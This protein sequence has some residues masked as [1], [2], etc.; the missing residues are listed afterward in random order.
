MHIHDA[1]TTYVIDTASFL[2]VVGTILDIIP[3]FTAVLSL[4]WI[5]LRIYESVT[6]KAF[7]AQRRAEVKRRESCR[8]GDRG[9]G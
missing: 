7:L 4:V 2:A 3:H 5:S 9:E 8:C 1:A 6:V